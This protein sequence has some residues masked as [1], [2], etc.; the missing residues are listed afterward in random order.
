MRLLFDLFP[1]IL[2]F[3]AYKT[4]GIYE[5]TAVAIVAGV[6]QIV[7]LKL[8]RKP[9]DNMQWVSLAIIVVFGGMTLLLHDETFIKWKP[10][11]LY[12]LFAIVLLVSR[13]AFGRNLIRA[14]MS[15]QVVLPAPIWER[16]NLAWVVFFSALGVLNIVVAYNFS[17]DAWV[18][19]KLFGTLGLTLAFVVGQALYFSRHIQEEP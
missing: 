18:D 6:G 2:F 8:R 11:V 14:M 5:A 4:W 17:T 3:I 13:L 12:G 16:L 7:W 19:F 1:V 15:K 9:V 10:T